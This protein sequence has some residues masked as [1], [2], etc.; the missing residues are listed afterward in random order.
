MFIPYLCMEMEPTGAIY[1]NFMVKWPRGKVGVCKTLDGGSNPPLTSYVI[2]F[3]RQ[4]SEG[5]AFLC[6]L[7]LC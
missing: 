5:P 3:H 7:I 6:G 1:P 4:A 2:G